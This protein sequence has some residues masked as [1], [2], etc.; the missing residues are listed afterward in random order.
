LEIIVANSALNRRQLLTY[1]G[2]GAITWGTTIACQSQPQTSTPLAQAKPQPSGPK[3][4]EFGG[5]E[6]WIN[7][8]A[9]SL[10]DLK[11]QIVLIHIWTFACINCQR[12]IPY[13]VQWHQKY[14]SQGLKVVSIHT[15]EFAFERDINNVKKAVQKHDIT[16]PVAIDNRSTMWKAYNNEYWPHLFLADRTGTIRYD[17]IGEGAY[18]RTE[19]TIR[20]L[21][22]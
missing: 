20:Q 11:G 1:L 5:I 3:L 22:G 14:A 4:P 21:L 17:H 12:T 10:N 9:L 19:Q 16:Y 6:Q 2:L 13:I 15:P 8:P 7:S 18:D